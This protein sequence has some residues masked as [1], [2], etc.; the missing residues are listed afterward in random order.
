MPHLEAI[1]IHCRQPGALARFYAEVPDLPVDP[2]DDD[3]AIT[4]PHLI[5]GVQLS[6]AGRKASAR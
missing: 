6:F 1:V 5:P 3:D 4:A 2:D